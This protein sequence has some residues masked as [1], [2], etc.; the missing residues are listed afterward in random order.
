[1]NQVFGTLNYIKLAQTFVR[2]FALCFCCYYYFCSGRVHPVSITEHKTYILI[3]IFYFI[4]DL[5]LRK[6]ATLEQIV[7]YFLS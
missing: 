1:M 5:N 4:N 2:V 6:T 3:Q 7:Q